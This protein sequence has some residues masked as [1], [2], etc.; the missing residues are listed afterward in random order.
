MAPD[1]AHVV[2]V[3]GKQF[4]DDLLRLAAVGALEVPVPTRVTGASSEPRMWSRDGSTSSA[5]SEC[6]PRSGLAGAR[7]RSWA[8]AGFTLSTDKSQWREDHGPERAQLSLVEQPAV[9]RE[10]RDQ[11]R[12]GEAD[13]AQRAAGDHHRRGSAAGAARAE[14]PRREPG[15]GRDADRLA[16]DVASRM[17]SVTGEVIASPSSVPVTCTP[18]F[19]SANNGTIT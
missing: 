4:A 16:H 1:I 19:A 7:E 12:D 18:A 2:A 8:G 3:V 9:E 14:P 6:R 11:Q 17:P 15:P 5:R 10:A 13:P